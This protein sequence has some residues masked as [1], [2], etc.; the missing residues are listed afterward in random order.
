MG[1][2]VS[3]EGWRMSGLGS[4]GE[5]PSQRQREGGRG[6]EFWEGGPGEEA[7]LGM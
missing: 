7:T 5:V 3:V 2:W 1:E 6:E 4:W